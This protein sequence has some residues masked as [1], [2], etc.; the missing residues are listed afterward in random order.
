MIRTDRA[1]L[2]VAAQTHAGMTGKNNEDR[3]AITSFQAGEDDLTP[4]LFAIVADGIGGHRA[5]EVAA[6][7]AVNHISQAVAESDTQRPKKILERAIHEASEAIAD[8]ASASSD[9][10]GMGATCACVLVIGD[11]LYTATV[12]D[13]R[14]YL[15]REGRIQ[16]LTTDHTWVQEA[17]E[18]SILTPEQARD[19]P[20]VHVIRRYLGSPDP[21]EVDFRLRL[22]DSEADA[23]AE[24]NQGMQIRYGDTLL[25]CSDGLTDLVWNDEI[26]EIIRAKSSLKAAAQQLIDTANQRG[27][28]DNTTI[29]LINVPRNVKL[30]VPQKTNWRPWIIGGGITLLLVLAFASVLTV[31][32]LRATVF[33]TPTSTF[34]PSLVPSL[35]LT[36]TPTVPPIPTETLTMTPAPLEP[37]YTPWPTNTEI[38][39]GTQTP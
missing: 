27:G 1:H 18:K 17:I 36:Q 31:N 21:P 38:P 33:A 19:H 8:H 34:T 2:N 11:K 6:E 5:G 9:Q 28:H 10:K 29:V 14:I 32:L 23:L 16:Q 24:G 20:N 37:T 3:Y 12:G 25:I 30:S 22:Y 15:L 13:S 7:L 4:V 35:T 39:S 26:A